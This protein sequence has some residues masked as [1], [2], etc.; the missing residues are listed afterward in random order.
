[1]GT[2]GN[3]DTDNAESV[4]MRIVEEIAHREDVDPLELSPPLYDVIDPEVVESLVT[5]QG[6]GGARDD[7]RIEFTYL[8]YEITVDRDGVRI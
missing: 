8:G 5:E 3:P 7:A 6:T 1:M 4:T 2:R